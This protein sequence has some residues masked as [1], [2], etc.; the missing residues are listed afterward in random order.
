MASD[1]EFVMFVV[2][3]IGSAG[4][5]SCRKMFGE[6][7]IYAGGKV[8]ALICDNRVFVKPT[9][10]GKCF[11]GAVTE[12][13]PYPGAKMYYLVEDGFEDRQWFS[14]LIRITA[15]ELPLL[16]PKDERKSKSKS[17]TRGHGK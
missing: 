3:Q 12:A 2:D 15:R 8:V 13:P 5:I 16:K 14:D 1:K 10:G 7:A 6:Y 11:I 4:E 9:E 17:A